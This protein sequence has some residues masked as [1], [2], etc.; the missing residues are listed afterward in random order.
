MVEVLV[1][2]SLYGVANVGEV[3]DHSHLV[4]VVC[5][6][7]NLDEAVVAMKVSALSL[8]ADQSMAVAEIDGLCNAVG[9]QPDA[10]LLDTRPGEVTTRIDTN[11]LA[12]DCLT[13]Q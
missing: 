1:D 9:R 12:R 3:H 2:P 5:F 13:R 6:N 4:Q 8:V 7:V 10:P 11:H